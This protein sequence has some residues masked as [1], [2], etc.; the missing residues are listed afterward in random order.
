MGRKAY[1]IRYFKCV[2]CENTFPASMSEPL[3]TSRMR[4]AIT[5]WCPFYK[6][7][8]AMKQIDAEKM[9]I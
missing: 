6:C 4:H 2:G 5:M 9:R 3:T 8:R 1:E 7:D